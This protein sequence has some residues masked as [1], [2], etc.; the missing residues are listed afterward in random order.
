[1]RQHSGWLSASLS[2]RCRLACAVLLFHAT[3]VPQVAASTDGDRY[4]RSEAAPISGVP[5]LAQSP[6]DA[7]PDDTSRAEDEAAEQRF[8]V[9]EYRI[10]GADLLSLPEIET[11]LYPFLGPDRTPDDV[12]AARAALEAAYFDKGYQTIAVAVPP[13]NVEHGIV[14]LQV[15]EGAVGRLRVRGSRYFDL[16]A[17]KEAAPSL[18]EGTVPNLQEVTEDIIALNQIPDRR[19]TPTLRAG[20]APGTVDVDLNVEDTFPLHG[21]V[22]LNNR[23]SQDTTK[24][25]LNASLRYDNLWQLGHSINLGYQVAPQRRSDSEVFSGSYL[26]RF[27]SVPWFSGLVY[28]VK[29]DSDVSTLGDVNVA[30]QGE[31]IGGRALLTLPRKEG[32]FHTLS[33]GL[34]YKSFQERVTLD[35]EEGFSSPI[36]YYPITA[37]YAATWLGEESTTQLNVGIT[38]SFRGAGSER[39]DFDNRRSDATGSFLYFRGDA[40]HLQELPFGAQVFGE[41]QGQFSNDALISS[42]QFSAGGQDTVRG[43]LESEVLGDRAALGSLELRSP[44]VTNYFGDDILNDWRLHAFIEGG[45]VTI[46]EPLEEQIESFELWSFGVGTRIQL[47]D[48]VNGS[49]DVAVPMVEQGDTEQG[50]PRALFRAW[51]EF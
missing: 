27:Q 31:I 43:Y 19:V 7:S 16:D 36:T 28:G 18:A 23:Y 37:S 50:D 35:G 8:D 4:A 48:Y 2:G 40:S 24:L 49:F 51:L 20:V 5:L 32:F 10:E 11:A 1:M 9:F 47:L 46:N 3:A 26:A 22:E 45:H 44:S 6:D 39:D 12:D 17:I 41:V 13:Q 33:L 30:G 21:S 29:Q 15:T 38:G 42:E 34:D 14:T 25:R